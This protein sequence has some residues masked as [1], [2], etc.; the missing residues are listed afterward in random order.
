MRN[1]NNGCLQQRNLHRLPGILA[2]L[3]KSLPF[4]PYHVDYRRHRRNQ[5]ISK[6]RSRRCKLVDVEHYEDLE[7]GLHKEADVFVHDSSAA[8][9]EVDFIPDAPLDQSTAEFRDGHTFTL[10]F[11]VDYTNKQSLS[12]I[13][14]V[15]KWF[16]Y[17][18]KTNGK[19]QNKSARSG[20]RVICI[21][22]HPT[23]VDALGSGRKPSSLSHSGFY[24]LPFYH[25]SR[26]TLIRLLNVTRV[27]SIIVVANRDGKIVTHYGWEAIE[28]EGFDGRCLDQWI[29]RQSL[30][31]LIRK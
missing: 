8:N 19:S 25:S 23:E 27:P 12:A 13:S 30:E 17:A 14:V 26:F 18:L 22:N 3:P 10:F 28:R 15:R 6:R 5:H 2:A 9:T 20:N 16:Q 21:P 4:H 29:D 7:E 11:F 31:I 24:E 1:N